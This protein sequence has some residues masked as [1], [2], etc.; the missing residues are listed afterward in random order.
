MYRVHSY[1]ARVRVLEVLSHLANTVGFGIKVGTLLVL[2]CGL[3]LFLLGSL[4]NSRSLD[5]R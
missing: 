1:L 3:V 2:L 4:K 5:V